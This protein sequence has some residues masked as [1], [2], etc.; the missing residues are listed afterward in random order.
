M[1]YSVIVSYLVFLVNFKSV[2]GFQV[3]LVLAASLLVQCRP[4]HDESNLSTNTVAAAQKHHIVE[5]AA[6]A[7]RHR[8]VNRKSLNDMTD[9]ELYRFYQLRSLGF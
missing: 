9:E 4:S 8:R 1:K 6:K 3:L 5:R 7:K 2:C